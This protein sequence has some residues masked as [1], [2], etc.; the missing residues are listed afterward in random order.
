MVAMTR[1]DST[2][3]TPIDPRQPRRFEKKRNMTSA[4][5][6][7]RGS[8]LAVRAAVT[9]TMHIG[10][11]GWTVRQEHGELFSIEGSHLQRYASR[12]PAVEINSSFYKPHKR[13]TYERWA[14]SVPAAFRFSVKT[15]KLLTHERRLENAG[16][17]LPRF[18]D[19][20]AGLG[21][22]L[23]CVLI[24]LP[25]S[26]AYDPRAVEGFLGALRK[27][28]KGPVVLEPRHPT[29]FTD[30]ADRRLDGHRV[31]RVVADPLTDPAGD[32][33]GGW[34]G[35]AY[36]RLHGSPVLYQSSYDDGYLDR[37]VRRLAQ[38][39]STGESVWCIFD[40]T[41]RGAAITNARSVMAGLSLATAGQKDAVL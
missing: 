19:E 38:A 4:Y 2:S 1:A 13:A 15:P 36:F 32:E 7:H 17:D 20:I 12:F 35:V 27:R 18:L 16:V 40:N 11:A 3:E 6:G 39:E 5:R 14:V 31:A 8:Q 26:L 28:H 30:A 29:W 23:G 10:T 34:P 41:A 21:A 22:K 37:L 24:Q 9:P 25:P 33:P